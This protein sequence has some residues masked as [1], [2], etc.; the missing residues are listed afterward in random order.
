LSSTLNGEGVVEIRIRVAS[1]D[2]VRR[3]LSPSGTSLADG[4]GNQLDIEPRQAAG[5]RLAF[6]EQAEKADGR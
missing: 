3:Q 5:A 2:V 6:V 4:G 1:V